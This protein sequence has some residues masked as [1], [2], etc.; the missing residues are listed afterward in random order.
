MN[1]RHVLDALPLWAGEDLDPA[2][3]AEVEEHLEAC[4]SCRAEATALREAMAWIREDA[5]SPFSPEDGLALRRNVMAQVAREHPS[6]S[7]RRRA[8]VL[9]PAAA[10]LV[11]TAALGLRH[12]GQ[13]A[14]PL[15]AR[16]PPP[17]TQ[18]QLRPVDAPEAPLPTVRT[19]PLSSKPR[20]DP[21]P[22]SPSPSFTRLEFST[23]DPAIR[24]IWLAQ[25]EPAAPS[26]SSFQEHP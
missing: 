19:R 24:I 26:D 3:R 1:R 17:S 15:P 25:A 10:L 20:A 16:I 5:E 9:L 2:R 18:A 22:D 14:L 11:A 7:A 21:Q 4:A 8:W 13:R 6:R 12:L 23:G